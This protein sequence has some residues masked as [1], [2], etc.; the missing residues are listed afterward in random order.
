MKLF[1]CLSDVPKKKEATSL[2]FDSYHRS[3]TGFLRITTYTPP[4][5]VK[6]F[7]W[8]L[9]RTLAERWWPP[10][11]DEEDRNIKT[12]FLITRRIFARLNFWEWSLNVD[13]WRH[14]NGW[15]MIK[16]RPAGVGGTLMTHSAN[17]NR[18]LGSS[19]SGLLERMFFFATCFVLLNCLVTTTRC[20][21]LLMCAKA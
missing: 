15:D 13:K 18:H 2:H 11:V 20:R 10:L 3:Y 7:R 4:S 6:L 1:V 5:R 21:S 14:H 8:L 17:G 12:D 19:R 16:K 9:T